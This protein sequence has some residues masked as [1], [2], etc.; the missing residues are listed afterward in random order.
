MTGGVAHDFNNL[1]MIV[2]GSVQR[3]RRDLT[4]EKHVRLLDMIANAT[5]RGESLT[6]QLLAFS[7]RQMHTPAVIDLT[8]RLPELKEMLNRS[9]RGDITIEVAVPSKSCAVK[10]DPSEL[11]LALLNLAVN[12]RDAMPN[13]GVL[14]I[15]AKPVV[16]KGKAVEEGLAR[17][18]RRHPRD[19]QRRAASRRRCCRACSSRSSPP[20]RSARAPGWA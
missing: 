16:L 12:A 4:E 17:R 6:R 1:L 20:R 9:L 2:S 11:E 10:V 3:L 7:R 18:V 5:A 15:T 8:Q 14:G 19:R 13:G